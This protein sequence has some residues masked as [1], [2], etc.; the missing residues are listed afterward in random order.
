MSGTEPA[1]VLVR[2]T[3]CPVLT[4]R[5]LLRDVRYSHSVRCYAKY[6][7][8][9]AY[10]PVLA[11]RRLLR[12]VRACCY[13]L[14]TRY[15]V[16][17]GGMLLR[18]CYAKSGTDVACAGTSKESLRGAVTG[19]LADNVLKRAAEITCAKTQL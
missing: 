18:A 7:T 6:G 14:A 4:P 1:Y 3:R 2:A 8:R 9:I 19:M 13:A 17:R 5:V 10:A 15:P 11:R 16:L 12:A